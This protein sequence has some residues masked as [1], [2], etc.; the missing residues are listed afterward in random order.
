MKMVDRESS[1]HVM[2]VVTLGGMVTTGIACVIYLA[3]IGE[4]CPP[5]GHQF[6]NFTELMQS[7]VECCPLECEEE[8][9]RNISDCNICVDQSVDGMIGMGY[10]PDRGYIGSVTAVVC[11]AAAGV[12]A[13]IIGCTGLVLS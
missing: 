9:Y 4:I 11:T 2:L 12:F 6:V 7:S 3:G 5:A 1:R 10:K 8:T 13:F